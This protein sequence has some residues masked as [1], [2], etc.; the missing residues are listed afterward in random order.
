MMERTRQGEV[1]IEDSDVVGVKDL[2]VIR[3][4]NFMMTE[5]ESVWNILRKLIT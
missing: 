1:K 2:L 5:M 3:T 4:F